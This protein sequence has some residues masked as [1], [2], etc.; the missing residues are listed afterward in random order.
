[1]KSKNNARAIVFLNGEVDYIFS[2]N[3][4]ATYLSDL[5]IYCADGAWNQLA[6]DTYFAEKVTAVIGDGDSIAEDVSMTFIQLGDQD[7]TDFEKVLDLLYQKGIEKIYVFGGGGGEMDHYLSNLSVMFRYQSQFELCMI[8]RYG[9]SFFIPQQWKA[10][11]RVGAMVSVMPFPY[12]H[13]VVYQGLMYPL[14]GEDLDVATR[15]GVRNC[16][17]AEDISI[18][19]NEGQLLV[20]VAHDSK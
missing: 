1:M 6:N 20:F 7:T 19:Y 8:D 9:R 17:V 4:I 2:R 10:K 15:T 13:S 11:V 16:A 18:E 5:E 3:Y 14:M 12:A